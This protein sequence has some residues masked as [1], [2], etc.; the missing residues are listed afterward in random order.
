METLDILRNGKVVRSITPD[1]PYLVKLDEAIT[2]EESGW[3]AA[4]VS[5]PERQQ[6][7]M[8]GYVYAHTSPVYVTKGGRPTRS[9]E[10]ARYFVEWIDEILPALEEATCRQELGSSTRI[11][12]ACF[13]SPEQKQEV[14][15]IWRKARRLYEG[16]TK[17]MSPALSSGSGDVGPDLEQRLPG[18]HVQGL[19]IRTSKRTVRNGIFGNG[20]EFL[21]LAVGREHVDAGLRVQ[22]LT[23]TSKP[24]E[25]SGHI[26]VT[27][28]VDG[29]PIAAATWREVV[30]HTHGADLSL[31]AQVIGPN[32]SCATL[33]VI[34]LDQ[35]QG[36]IRYR[37]RSSGEIT[38]P[39]GRSISGSVKMRSIVPSGSTR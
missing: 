15:G 22:R 6:L 26:E 24:V 32:H 30:E 2:V 35:V 33:A 21:E 16:L 28:A 5:G 13:D 37:V 8:D 4:R 10:D 1:D 27:F 14:V 9:P 29:H 12:N 20:N 34:G 25:T 19:R 31:L 18:G 17:R 36:T 11:I 23:R 3:L 39:F 7:M 38:I